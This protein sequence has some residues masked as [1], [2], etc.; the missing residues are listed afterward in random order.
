MTLR[1][2]RL[3][4]MHEEGIAF[5]YMKKSILTAFLWLA[6]VSPAYGQVAPNP[7][8]T[9][10]EQYQ[11]TLVQLITLLQ[12]QVASL[13]AQLQVLQA[14]QAQLS[15]QVTQIVQ[16]T[17]PVQISGGIGGPVIAQNN[18]LLTISLRNKSTI[19]NNVT[20]V[21]FDIEN[22]SDKTAV[23]NG[24]NI[25]LSCAYCKFIKQSELAVV[26]DASYSARRNFL[27]TTT[28]NYKGDV[29]FDKSLVIQPYQKALVEF[30]L[31]NF[32]GGNASS[33]MELDINSFISGQSVEANQL[34]FSVNLD[35]LTSFAR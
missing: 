27:S 3:L 4:T 17:T 10:Q 20:T 23:I 33:T 6:L 30:D 15:T 1:V 5:R 28:D 26:G 14:S 18:P 21:M 12:A 7:A 2:K 34:P 29:A 35:H 22:V 9:L 8:P 16:N 24:A 25:Y 19:N 31:Y 32:D 11:A 13:I